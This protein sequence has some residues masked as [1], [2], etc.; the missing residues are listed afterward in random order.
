MSIENR[1]AKSPTPLKK[2]PKN[3]SKHNNNIIYHTPS[4]STDTSQEEEMEEGIQKNV[5]KK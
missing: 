5:P 1:K 4:K 2:S 3:S